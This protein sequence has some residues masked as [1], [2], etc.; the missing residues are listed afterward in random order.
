MR[1]KSGIPA[2]GA[3][4]EFSGGAMCAHHDAVRRGAGMATEV[5]TVASKSLRRCTVSP[6]RRLQRLRR[7]DGFQRARA[8]TAP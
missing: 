1:G 8:T 4:T 2:F 7:H 5:L 6:S 3:P